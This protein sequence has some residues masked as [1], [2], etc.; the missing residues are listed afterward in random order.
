MAPDTRSR[1]VCAALVFLVLL[2][3]LGLFYLTAFFKALAPE[4]LGGDH[5]FRDLETHSSGVLTKETSLELGEY[6]EK[7]EGEVLRRAGPASIDGRWAQGRE[8][9][10]PAPSFFQ[11]ANSPFLFDPMVPFSAPVTALQQ[12]RVH[13]N[14]IPA[15]DSHPRS[16]ALYSIDHPCTRTFPHGS[17]D[18][19]GHADGR[20]SP[21]P[22]VQSFQLLEPDVFLESSGLYGMSYVRESNVSNGVTKRV[23]ILPKSDFAE[24]VAVLYSLTMRRL[25]LL[26]LTWSNRRVLVVDHETFECIGSLS[27]ESEG[28]GFVSNLNLDLWSRLKKADAA[29]S[30]A[31]AAAGKNAT[32][33]ASFPDSVPVSANRHT[34][35][36]TRESLEKQFLRSVH[37][38]RLWLTTGG[39]E[40][41][42][43]NVPHL[44]SQIEKT[45]FRGPNSRRTGPLQSRGL[46]SAY[47]GALLIRRTAVVHCLGRVVVGLNELEF[48]HTTGELFANMYGVPAL[49]GFDPNT[50]ACTKLVSLSGAAIVEEVSNSRRSNNSSFAL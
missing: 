31:A 43:V 25:L 5:E 10:F 28:W 50:G 36:V 49:I 14:W 1:R 40:L 46:C 6:A 41:L 45:G 16:P 12:L 30:A 7:R 29:V 15:E 27:V 9:L 13:F 2:S 17:I 32:S 47:L 19:E 24:G 3:I 23:F 18:L 44:L 33:E 22:F 48:N 34:L 39:P 26:V 20:I 37:S 21:P 42:E 4:I 38:Q 11:S 8:V 35:E